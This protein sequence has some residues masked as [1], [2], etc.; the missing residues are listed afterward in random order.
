[1]EKLLSNSKVIVKD[2]KKPG[3]VVL[4]IAGVHGNEIGGVKA[5]NELV[6]KIVPLKGKVTFIYANL[7]AIKQNKRFVEKNLNRCFFDKQPK[8]LANSLEGK[9]ARELLPY[10]EEADVLLDLHS[11]KSS[12]SKKYVLCEKDC[13]KFVD[14]LPVAIVLIGTDKFLPGGSDGYM[15]NHKKPGMCIE[16]GLH[17]SED[18]K[19]T[20]KEAVTNLLKKLEMIPGVKSKYSQGDF[21]KAKYIYKNRFAEFKLARKFVDFEPLKSKELIGLEGEK[22]IFAK[23]G[24]FILFPDDQTELNK[25]C[26]VIIKKVP[27]IK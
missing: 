2:S 20:A 17:E 16:C 10:L 13:F 18:S 11:S 27:K 19:A 8:E 21:Y 7:E 3:P 25:E 4:I 26:F 12:N 22:K 9:T 6:P 23:K 1:M 15:F 24:E 14:A 5:L